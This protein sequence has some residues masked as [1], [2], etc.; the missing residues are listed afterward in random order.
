MCEK[1]AGELARQSL[2]DRFGKGEVIA[3]NGG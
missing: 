1:F 3:I 2:I